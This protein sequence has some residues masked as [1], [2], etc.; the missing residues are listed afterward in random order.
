MGIDVDGWTARYRS[1]AVDEPAVQVLRR[2]LA[3]MKSRV[4][5]LLFYDKQENM[6]ALNLFGVPDLAH[7]LTREATVIPR[8]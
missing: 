7:S 6:C 2:A 5:W 8:P 4:S 3:N 1:G